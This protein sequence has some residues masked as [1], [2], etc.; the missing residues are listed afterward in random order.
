MGFYEYGTLL[1]G[2]L[3]RWSSVMISIKNVLYIK[4]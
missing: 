4:V 3:D 1:G 2:P